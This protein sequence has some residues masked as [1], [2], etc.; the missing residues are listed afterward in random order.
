MISAGKIFSIAS[1]N[2]IAHILLVIHSS[3]ASKGSWRQSVV[4]GQQY[5][6]M[7]LSAKILQMKILP[8]KLWWW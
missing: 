4:T 5:K 3:T 1:A 2:E 7:P 6:S 8:F